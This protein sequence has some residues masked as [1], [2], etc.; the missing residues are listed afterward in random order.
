MLNQ[1]H[2]SIVNLPESRFQNHSYEE[3]ARAYRISWEIKNTIDGRKWNISI[4]ERKVCDMIMILK[5]E[6]EHASQSTDVLIGK[7]QNSK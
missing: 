5:C 7:N 1:I 4:Q 2:E 3:Q 6:V